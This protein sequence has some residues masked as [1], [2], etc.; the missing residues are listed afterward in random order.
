MKNL[1]Y[2][3]FVILSTVAL[4]MVS[5][6][7]N[8][9]NAPDNK[10]EAEKHNDAKF[11]NKAEKDAQF[12]VEAADIS[13]TEMSL[14]QLAEKNAMTDDTKE[15]GKMMN[16][17]HKKAYD[18]LASL[19]AKKSITVPASMSEGSKKDYDGLMEK[20]GSD[21]DKKYCSMM[22]DG[23][24]SAIDK[25]EKAS[26]DAV[27]PDIQAWATN[28]LPTLRSHLDHAMSC[29]EKAKKLK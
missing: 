18:D 6:N 27:D 25:F 23:H 19:A 21:F 12:V 13:L 28:M 9:N 24:K 11:D 7:N 15:L 2:F 3:L 26:K 22:V 4:G 8:D 16:R 29:D 17:D 5:C 14:G 1:K 10:N 20:K